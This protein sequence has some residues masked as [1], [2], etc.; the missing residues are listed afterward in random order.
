MTGLGGVAEPPRFDDRDPLHVFR[1]D[2]DVAHAEP[3]PYLDLLR[4]A[5]IAA[6]EE[7]LE[8]RGA[9]E[10]V[11]GPDEEGHGSVACVLDHRPVEGL[12]RCDRQVVVLRAQGVERV[13]AQARACGGRRH[14]V[15]EEHGERV[16][17]R[18]TRRHAGDASPAPLL[19]AGRLDVRHAR[20]LGLACCI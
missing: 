17:A 3:G 16:D 14:Q 13:L 20:R 12:D 19:V 8:P 9:G 10:R 7:L 11:A 2:H 6:F 4:R 15:G 5:P 18:E 1:L